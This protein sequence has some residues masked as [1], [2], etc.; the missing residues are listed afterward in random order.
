MGLGRY[1]SLAP[2]P[3]MNWMPGMWGWKLGSTTDFKPL[4]PAGLEPR[5]GLMSCEPG[6]SPTWG[7]QRQLSLSLW[8]YVCVV[9]WCPGCSQSHQHPMAHSTRTRSPVVSACRHLGPSVDTQAVG[10]T[11]GSS[12]RKEQ[13][14]NWGRDLDKQNST[15]AYI[16]LGTPRSG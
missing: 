7:T 14:S 5:G 8:V 12:Q 4:D 9:G 13:K 10:W 16:F 15:K 11:A 2:D 1:L 3:L 6:L